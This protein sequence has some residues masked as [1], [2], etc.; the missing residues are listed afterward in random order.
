MLSRREE[1][2]LRIIRGNDHD[3][4]TLWWDHDFST[5]TWRGLEVVLSFTG[6]LAA[7]EEW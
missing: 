1:F 6:M 5:T 3:M 2:Y 7:E 4:N